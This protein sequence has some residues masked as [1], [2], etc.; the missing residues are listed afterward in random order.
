MIFSD[1][2]S[3]IVEQ[4]F[5]SNDTSKLCYH[6]YAHTIEVAE[7]VLKYAQNQNLEQAE[8]IYVAGLFHDCGYL[9]GYQ[10]HEE[11]S[12]EIAEHFLRKIYIPQEEI[13]FINECIAATELG[14]KPKH[15]EAA[16]LKDTDLAYG[17][18]NKFK[19]RGPML[20][21]EWELNL[22][23]FYTNLD[24]EKLQLDFLENLRFESSFANLNF[25]SI[26]NDNLIFQ[27]KLL[28]SV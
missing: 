22:N 8:L 10:K 16:L 5:I 23:K 14:V 25:I 13:S 15:E 12:M 6:S 2:I 17:V 19:E 1:K 3:A 26:V 11:K 27:R 20:R 28:S 24:W 4:L 7:S 9:F 21:K 18:T